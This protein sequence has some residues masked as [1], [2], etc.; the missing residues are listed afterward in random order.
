MECS[1]ET[2]G[3]RQEEPEGFTVFF[4]FFFFAFRQL[5]GSS[6]RPGIC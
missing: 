6:F 5:P 3:R 4:F 2:G 1:Q